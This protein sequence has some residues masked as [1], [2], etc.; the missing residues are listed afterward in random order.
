MSLEI[1]TINGQK[2]V[3]GLAWRRLTET[4]GSEKKEIRVIAKAENAK[5]AAVLHKTGIF[6]GLA[7]EVLPKGAVYSGAIL[8]INAGLG[9]NCI[10]VQQIDDENYAVVGIRNGVPV[11]GMDFVADHATAASKTNEFIAHSGEIGIT[12]YSNCDFF[13]EGKVYDF[14]T[15]DPEHVPSAKLIKVGAD[16]SVPV[17]IILVL[18]STAVGW[19]FYQD[20]QAEQAK[21]AKKKNQVDPVAQYMASASSMLATELV[22]PVKQTGE[23]Y[24]DIIGQLAATRAGWR[25]AGVYCQGGQCVISWSQVPG[26]TNRS[27]SE[28]LD[29]NELAFK[30]D[31]KGI[32]QSL[33][34]ALPAP[35]QPASLE[36][37]PSTTLFAIE[38]GSL[39][40][41]ANLA[42]L[43]GALGSAEVYGLAPGAQRPP[44]V[45]GGFLGRGA[46]TLQGSY[47]LLREVLSELPGNMTLNALRLTADQTNPLQLT[48]QAEGY[49]YVRR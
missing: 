35:P 5:M 27:F 28:G 40:Q 36:G 31:G 9:D 37:L 25:I 23:I 43:Q 29:I 21:N 32:E 46:W 44:S 45:P 8:L 17:L 22:Q 48:L 47:A 2:V 11:T 10:V 16:W 18:L 49:Y 30:A 12:V 24:F 34:V 13:D 4:M 3:F 39:F 41:K 14:N 20:W 6:C 1:V 26:G 15:L 38:T 42:G 7:Q 19:V 33:S